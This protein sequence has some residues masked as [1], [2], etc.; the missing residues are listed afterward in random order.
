IQRS[1]VWYLVSIRMSFKAPFTLL[2]LAVKSLLRNEALAISTLQKLPMELF[3]SLFKEA[4]KSRHMKILTAMVAE[5]PFS[6][7][8]VGAL[9]QVPD[10][11]ILQAVLDGVDMLLIQNVH[12]RKSKLR[13]LDLRNVH[14]VF[15][16]AWPG[17]ECGESSTGT[18]SKEQTGNCLNRYA[19]RQLL[20]VVTD[21]D[22]RTHLNE[23]QAYLLQ[24]AQQQ[25]GSVRLCCMKVTICDTPMKIIKMFFSIFQP[26]YI[27]ELELSTGWTPA[28]LSCFARC[29]GQMRNLRKLHLARIYV[30]TKKAVNS[31]EDIEEKY[32]ARLISQISKLN[33]LQHLF[34]NGVYFSSEHMKQ[35]FRCLKSPLESLSIKLSEFSQS[36]LEHLCRCQRLF[37][38][39][40]LTLCGV[41]LFNLCPALLQFLLENVA[42]TLQ[43]LELEDCGIGDSQ[44]S[45]LLPAL[46]QC[47]QLTRVNFYD[48]VISISVLMDLLQILANLSKLTEEFY[49]A[50][51]ECYDDLGN[52]QVNKFASVCPDLLDILRAK[53]QPI[54]VTFATD[55]CLKCHQRCVF[56]GKTRLCHCLS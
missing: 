47:L 8:P 45:A 55:I 33:C 42:A 39:K 38:L 12:L 51:M 18:L 5:W 23:Q 56:D 53:R 29:F 1:R 25:K 20:K 36:D 43:I 4:F 15:W 48:N 11:V 9:M 16:D 54:R 37:Q 7:L 10:V 22:L 2:E 40:H 32:T 49:P 27:E 24:W 34:I 35:L 50:P 3:P 31:L 46:S 13:V 17:I 41:V 26:C 28:A 21:F 52:V 44:L 30:N 6:C 14:H 19:L